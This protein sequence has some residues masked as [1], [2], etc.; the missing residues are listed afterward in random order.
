M[1]MAPKPEPPPIAPPPPGQDQAAAA[2]PANQHRHRHHRPVRG[3]ASINPDDY[4]LSQVQSD[5]EAAL[6]ALMADWTDI[7]D[8]QRDQI[9]DQ[10]RA[11]I[12][13]RDPHALAAITVDSATGTAL[14]A[15]AMQAH[16]EL[17]ATRVVDEAADQGVAT[18]P[19]IPDSVTI[20]ALAGVVASLL[21]AGLAAAAGREALHRYS[22]TADGQQVADAVDTYI[23]DLSPRTLADQLGGALTSAQ[24]AGRMS[25]FAVAPE[26]ALYA[27]EVMDKNTCEPCREVNGRWLGNIS[28]LDQ[29]DKAYPNG[30]YVDCEGGNRC[31]GTIVGV[32]RPKQ[33]GSGNG[34]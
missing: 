8:A 14:L 24:N 5:W 29:V 30:G 16:A 10:V 15:E 1:R 17:A 18:L 2:P 22:S 13:N 26:G 6:T 25:T 3:A 4:D 9:A 12:N 34:D 7:T 21:A 20:A 33:V 31:R 23:A 28:Q 11:A 27:S 32:W 19:G